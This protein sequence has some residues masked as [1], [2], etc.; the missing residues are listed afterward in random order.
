MNYIAE[1]NAFE[2]WLETN[3]LPALSQLL[4][5]K[6][7]MLANR[8]GWVEWIVVDN[9]R[10]MSLIQL[11]REATFI[12][13]RQKLIDKGLIEYRKG[14]KGSP[15]QYRIISLTFKLKAQTEVQTVVYTE[16][17]TVAQTADIYKQNENETKQKILKKNIKKKSTSETDR[18]KIENKINNLNFSEKLKASLREFV[19]Y[20]K[21]KTPMTSLAVEKMINML[22][23]FGY[24]EEN[25]IKCVD[26][27]IANGWRGIFPLNDN[28][29]RQDIKASTA[30][31]NPFFAVAEQIAKAEGDF[32]NE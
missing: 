28:E 16:V 7:L 24:S 8:A 26:K 32:E 23:G 1:I 27:A 20:R 15:N 29:L 9:Q 25:M 4:W 10:L 13:L 2:R 6:M 30:S 22:L 18:E 3:Y 31:G 17:E 14:K 11:K 12:D 5:Y 19:E 21:A